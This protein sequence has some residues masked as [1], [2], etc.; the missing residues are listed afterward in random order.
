MN[1]PTFIYTFRFGGTAATVRGRDRT[2]AQKKVKAAL[3]NIPN[4]L[5]LVD[6]T[7]VAE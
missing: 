7:E 6:V 5:T 2:E 4:V 1:E 3:G